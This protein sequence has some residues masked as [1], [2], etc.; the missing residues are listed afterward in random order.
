[1]A[2]MKHFAD[3]K[4]GET[5]EITHVDHRGGNGPTGG[6]WGWSMT[7]NETMKVTRAIK[8]KAF[9]SKH[10]CD[11]RCTGATGKNCEC[12]C[13]GKNHGYSGFRCE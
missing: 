12:S 3:M 9:P 7:R 13:G 5:I 10:V 8:Y 11:A 2:T 6:S 4:N 1:M